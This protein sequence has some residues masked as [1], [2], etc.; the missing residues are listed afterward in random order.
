MQK[1]FVFI[2]ENKPYFK[3]DKDKNL[4]HKSH[5]VRM[6]LVYKRDTVIDISAQSPNLNSFENL[7]SLKKRIAK[8]QPTSM[9]ALKA[10]ILEKLQNIPANYDLRKIIHSMKKRVN[11]VAD[12]KGPL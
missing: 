2:R 7:M 11:S 10:A 8:G 3:L 1:K 12:A 9:A 5:L 4:K 6:G